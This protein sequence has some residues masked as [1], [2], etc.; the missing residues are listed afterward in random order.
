MEI[1]TW[2]WVGKEERSESCPFFIHSH[3]PCVLS[4]SVV[5]YII[6]TCKVVVFSR[7]H[8]SVDFDKNSGILLIKLSLF[9]TQLSLGGMWRY[10]WMKKADICIKITN[11]SILFRLTQNWC[12]C[13]RL[14]R[15]V[16]VKLWGA[17]SWVSYITG[18]YIE[19]TYFI[20]ALAKL[21]YYFTFP[22]F[23][24]HSIQAYLLI[25]S[26]STTTQRKKICWVCA[27]I[28]LMMV[29]E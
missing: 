21:V 10:I 24:V 6:I 4:Q 27:L 18:M 7:S 12:T 20:I 14:G 25:L 26:L 28:M 5:P 22:F 2:C 8:L 3:L 19:Y 29:A 1:V 15:I 11:P 9:S 23:C 16:V 17:V 13:R